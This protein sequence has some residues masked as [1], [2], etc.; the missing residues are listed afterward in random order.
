MSRQVKGQNAISLEGLFAAGD[1]AHT[2]GSATAA[3]YTSRS[4]TDHRLERVSKPLVE[5]MAQGLL[6]PRGFRCRLLA[7]HWAL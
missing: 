1:R 6:E 4:V 2:S 3:V 5:V 7:G